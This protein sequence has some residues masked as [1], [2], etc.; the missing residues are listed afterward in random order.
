MIEKGLAFERAFPQSALRL[1]VCE[2]LARAFREQGDARRAIDAAA[3]GLAI[4]PDYI[5]LL[6]DLADLVANSSAAE[7]DRANTAATRALLLLETA[8][9]PAR[10]NADAWLAS[11]ARLRARAHAA[12]GL[13]RFKREDTAGARRA[14]EAALAQAS[15]EE[16]PAIHYRLGRLLAAT[17]AKAE[18]RRHLEAAARSGEKL[19]RERALAALAEL[20]P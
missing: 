12:L 6:V 10:A 9:A 19:L 17:G 3:A 15:A 13:V 5:P 2:L 16:N 14:L 11:V 7:L 1:P 20:R 4:A 18:A 8:R